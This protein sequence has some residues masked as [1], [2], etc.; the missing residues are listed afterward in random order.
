MSCFE[1][2]SLSSIILEVL[3]VQLL[4]LYCYSSIFFRTV[5]VIVVNFYIFSNFFWGGLHLCLVVRLS[6]PAN[7]CVCLFRSSFQVLYLFHC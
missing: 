2:V 3:S 1:N 7:P 5:L 6:I 4:H